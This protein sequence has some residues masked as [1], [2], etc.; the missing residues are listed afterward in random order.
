MGQPIQA[1]GVEV[2]QRPHRFGQQL[3]PQPEQRRQVVAVDG[4]IEPVDQFVD[5]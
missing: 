3:L 1:R 4:D 5:G 2:A